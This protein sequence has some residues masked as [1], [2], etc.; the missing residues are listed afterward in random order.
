MKA[1]F[2]QNMNQNMNQNMMM[3]GCVDMCMMCMMNMA[4]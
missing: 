3:T 4:Y 1:T 2:H